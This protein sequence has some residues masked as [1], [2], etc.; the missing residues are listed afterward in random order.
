MRNNTNALFVDFVPKFDNY[1]MALDLNS[2][3]LAAKMEEACEIFKDQNRFAKML[4]S[5]YGTDHSWL[6]INGA[7]EKY[8][9]LLVDL[10]V[11]KPEVL[12]HS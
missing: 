10:K 6:K 4:K 5:S 1:E 12:E 9:K 7:I 3:A 8:A 2:T 11:M